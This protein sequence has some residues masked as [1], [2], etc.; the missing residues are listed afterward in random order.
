MPLYITFCGHRE[1]FDEKLVY[2]KLLSLLDD[3]YAAKHFMSQ[4]PDDKVIVY[5]CG[6]YG[7]FDGLVSR[8]IDEMKKRH[9][10]I[11]SKKIFVTPYIT[12]SAQ[13]NMKYI[14]DYYDEILYP[15]LENVPPKYAIAK[16]NEWMIRHSKI[17]IA[18]VTHSWGGAAKTLEYARKKRLAV[19]YIKD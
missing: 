1:V 19:Y 13:E 3:F 6:G 18:Y 4:D 2:S 11:K 12:E 5:Y 8:A 10:E 7:Q 16:R 17:L 9:P 14:K 15:P